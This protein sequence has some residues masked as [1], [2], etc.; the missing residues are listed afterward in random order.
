MISQPW[1]FAIMVKTQV[2]I[3]DRLF[4]R[5]KQV[6]AAKEWSFAEIVRRGLEQMVFRH[7]ER[8][9][10]GG[11][12]WRLPEPVNLGLRLDPFADPEWREDAN[13]GAGS[14][15]LVAESLREE[16]ARYEAGA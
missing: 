7:P 16:A 9:V 14:A 4:E 8:D 2:Q 11:G 5:A 10:E 6:A 3:P 1:H 12:S 15:R 13:L